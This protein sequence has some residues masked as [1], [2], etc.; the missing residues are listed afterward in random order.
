MQ[1]TSTNYSSQLA[2]NS[3]KYLFRITLRKNSASER[4]LYLSTN[5]NFIAYLITEQVQAD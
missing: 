2:Q 5:L 1:A 4:C 3:P